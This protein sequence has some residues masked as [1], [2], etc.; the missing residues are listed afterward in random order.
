MRI[1]I[2]GTG[3]MGSGLGK[4][5]STKGHSVLVGSRDKTEGLRVGEV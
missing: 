4:Q 3:S 2:V 5:F 1:G